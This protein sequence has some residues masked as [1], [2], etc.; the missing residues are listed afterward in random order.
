MYEILYNWEFVPRP[1]PKVNVKTMVVDGKHRFFMKNH[2]MGTLYDL[3]ELS[4]YI[5]GLI[6]GERTMAEIMAEMQTTKPD[7]Q[8]IKILQTILF[9]AES[10]ALRAVLEPIRRKR[11]R[12]D[13]AFKVHIV[14]VE[15]SKRFLQSI[16]RVIRPLLRR[17]LLWVSLALIVLCGL[18]FAG[19]FVH[20][21]GDRRNF[22]IFG[23]TVVGLFVFNFVILAPV[24]AIHEIAHGLAVVHYGGA[25][26][27]MGTGWFYFGP[28]FYCDATDAWTFSRRNRIMVMLAGN[29][30]TMLIGSAIMMALYV[31]PF[32]PSISHML[33][34]TA[35]W[36]FYTSLWNFAPPFE[37]DGYY[38]L[39]DL[40]SMPNLRHDAYAYLKTIVKRSLKKPVEEPEG[41]TVGKKRILLGYAIMSVVW[42]MYMAYQSSTIMRYMAKDA[43]ISLLNISSAILFNQTLSIAGFAVSIVSIVYFTMMVS[44]YFFIFITAIKK[45]AVRA[46][47]FETIHDRDL[48]V[49]LYLPTQVPKSLVN[50]LK[51][52]MA[53]EAKKFT[54]NFNIER[55][56]PLCIAVLRMGSKRLALV[57]IKEH[58]RK[59]ELTFSSMYQKFLQRYKDD[60]L[61]SAGIYG[62]E[63]IKLTNLLIKMAK[64]STK[65][66]TPEAKAVAEQVIEGQTR[67][68][69][70]LLNS[71]SGRVWTIELPPAQQYEIEKSLLPTLSIEDISITDLYDEVE[72]F[73]KRIIYGFDSLAKLALESQSSLSEMLEHPEEHQLV[74]FFQPVKGRLIFVGR[75][76]QIEKN[77]A[78]FGSLF[79]D[80]AWCSYM[81][82]LLS[83]TNHILSVLGST[84]L[85]NE[86]EIQGMSDAE[87]TVL[88][89]NLS[90]VVANEGFIARSLE[91]CE[92]HLQSAIHNLRELKK[93]LET[94]IAFKVG[95]LDAIFAL[96]AENLKNL[97][98]RFKN[99]KEAFQRLCI[100]VKRIKK[101]VEREHRKREVIFLRKRRRMMRI[102]PFVVIFSAVV[103]LVGIQP[104]L[105][106][107]AV[108]FLVAALFP[109]LVYW[110]IYLLMWRS[111][112]R[113]SGYSSWAFS[114]IQT[115]IFAL[116]Q[117]FSKFIAT[118]DIL[119]PTKAAVKQKRREIH[120]NL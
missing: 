38:V 115:F 11:V 28:M 6:D 44:G 19:Q 90:T 8:P 61:R 57:Q 17:T 10:G 64:E 55:I 74:A 79:V 76:E 32:S 45:A 47:P 35:F 113:V 33:S 54:V 96:N 110:V 31:W 59:V 58:L 91:K 70:Y 63:K 82:N 103:A 3:D 69:F 78:A 100:E 48:S 97:P 51:A 95:L 88:N 81:D 53:K 18:S 49:F 16:H 94:A 66:G 36:C 9:F 72:D 12:V 15:R 7:T 114:Q 68:T 120:E 37:T 112:H 62:P 73:K 107:V 87:L 13:S 22:E 60:I 86:E 109:Q 101:V 21:L 77:L 89:R 52:K 2:I 84:T 43:A 40:L 46:L 30:S 29:L 5:W 93:S 92:E 108:P 50:N 106:L 117:G 65:T 71:V 67:D 105:E 39:S 83:E 75:T 99:F 27:D 1:S 56:G 41:L 26:K 20:I 116:T 118:G 85:P 98:S 102:Y 111:F 42:L 14:I 119:T 104:A 80:Q 23:S 34:M 24:T 4:Y 25:P